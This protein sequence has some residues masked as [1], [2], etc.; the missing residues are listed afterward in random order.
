M[1]A[2]VSF[3][4]SSDRLEIC[5]TPDRPEYAFIGRSN[6]G[7]SSLI[8]CLAHK[9]GLA[10]TSGRPG[11]TKLIN[12]FWFDEVPEQPKSGWYLVD[13]PGYGYA[14]VSKTERKKWSKFIEEYLI[15]R[16]NLM[17]TF[18]LLDSRLE[19]QKIDME[20]INWLGSEGIPFVL[21]YTKV[22][23]LTKNA[24]AKNLAAYRRKLSETWETLPPQVI[25]SST[26][27]RGKDELL[28]LIRETNGLY[29]S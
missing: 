19:P 18:V 13:L 17:Y 21:V 15:K 8:N 7:K 5:P 24:L 28:E 25:T 6:V 27:G 9:K 4:K 14:A 2:P 23:K 16:E 1:F 20:F 3:V 29:Q 11:K 26:E 12:H 22:D 10:K